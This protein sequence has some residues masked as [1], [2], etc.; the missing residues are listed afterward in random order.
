MLIFSCLAISIVCR[1]VI[2]WME[3]SFVLATCQEERK[4]LNSLVHQGTA[5]RVLKKRLKECFGNQRALFTSLKAFLDRSE[6]PWSKGSSSISASA[7]K[8]LL[9]DR[10]LSSIEPILHGRCQAIN[11]I[12]YAMID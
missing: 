1:E 2:G 10:V 8:F 11:S 3:R 5:S 12:I 4:A 6:V 7:I 9:R